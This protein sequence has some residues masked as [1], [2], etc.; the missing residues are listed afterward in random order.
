MR[1]IFI[2][3]S[4]EDSSFAG[5]LYKELS[6]FE[7]RGFMDVNDV[8]SGRQISEKLRDSIRLSSAVVVIFSAAARKSNW[9]MLELGLAE[10]LGKKIIPVLAPGSVYEEAIPESLLDRVAIDAD[11]N[12]VQQVAAKIVATAT[13]ASVEE[14]LEKTLSREQS[15]RRYQ[16]RIST[17]L[18]AL[19][20][21]L[22]VLA[23]LSGYQ[24]LQVEQARLQ[25][26]AQAIAAINARNVAELTRIE[27]EETLARLQQ[28]T[29]GG[30]SIAISPDGRFIAASSESGS[31]Q[32]LDGR[33]VVSIL[34]AKQQ[35]S[36]LAFSPDGDSIAV[37]SWDSSIEVFDI[38]TGSIVLSLRGQE[39]GITDVAFSPDATKLYSRSL[40]GTLNTWDAATG[41]LLSTIEL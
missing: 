11:Q 4:R 40:D 22:A 1:D 25:A 21:M 7:V 15:K 5:Q 14:A 13:G 36:S 18:S 37:G 24:Y 29:S 16:R 19:S 3:Y 34:V 41:V 8:A 38:S 17:V 6:S 28:L 32:I 33:E 12:A 26:E 27:T 31:L 35:I 23:L 20:V 9:V 39:D 30:T 10:S 2:S